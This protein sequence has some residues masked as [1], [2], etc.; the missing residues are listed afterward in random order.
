VRYE[1]IFAPEADEDIF[2]LRAIDRAKVLDTIELHLRYE[3]EKISKSR[4][5]RLE[6]LERPQYRLRIDNIRVFY[7][8]VY[9]IN[10]GIVEILAVK[11]KQTSIQWLAN[12][13]RRQR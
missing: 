13:G 3:P 9:T 11:E 8:V 10:E 12:F 7:D 6:G 5:K 1:I 2:S 4:I